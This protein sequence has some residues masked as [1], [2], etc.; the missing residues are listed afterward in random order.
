VRGINKKNKVILMVSVT[1]LGG[2]R[3]VGRSAVLVEGKDNLLLDYGLD[4]Q[5][6]GVPTKPNLKLEGAF[7][8][9]AHLD[10]CGI[11]PELYMRGF[12]GSVYATPATLGLCKLLLEDSLKVQEKRGIKSHFGPHD[13]EKLEELS[14]PMGFGKKIQFKNSEVTLFS[15]GHVPG[16]ASILVETEGKRILYTGDIKFS[17]TELMKRAFDDFRDIDLLICESTY[18]KK[19]HPDRGQLKKELLRHVSDVCS[20]NGIALLPCFAVGRSQ[21]MIQILSELDVPLYLDGMGKKAT[22]I[23]L[24]HPESLRDPKKLKKAFGKARKIKKHWERFRLLGKPG[25]VVTTAGMLNGGPI[26]HYIKK[27]HKKENCSLYISGYQVS[28]TVGNVLQSTGRYVN[29][30][31][32]VKPKMQVLFRDWSAHC[33]RTEILGFIKKISPKKIIF[34]HGD[35]CG[36]FAR[37]VSGMGFEA[38]APKN[39]E[40]TEV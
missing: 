7:L 30:G 20:N 38:I 40:K 29:E 10:H 8:S 13:I 3:E 35:S 31:L 17:E 24:E 19:D 22:S 33:D 1:G 9:H 12:L 27:L 37:E 39:G 26:S 16:A 36:E 21:E 11:L 32:D 14:Q 28:G 25:V 5:N 4:V 23:I 18:T 34:N 6:M 15:A 2:F